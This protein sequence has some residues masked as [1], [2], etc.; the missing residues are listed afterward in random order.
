MKCKAASGDV[1]QSLI[2]LEVSLPS[3]RCAT[4]SVLESGTV[5]DLKRAAQKSLV[6]G[7]LRLATADGYLLNPTDS[8]RLS[9]LQDG[10]CIAAVAQQPKIAT[11]GS[12]FAL[13]CVGGDRIVTWGEA[14]NGADSSTIRRELR[15]GLCLCCDPNVAPA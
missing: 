7:F 1:A 2:E 11:S 10:D 13:W 9:G 14:H 8:L 4:V 3:G 15:S 6:Q 12:A 5:A